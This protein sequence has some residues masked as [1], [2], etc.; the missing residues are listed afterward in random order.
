MMERRTTLVRLTNHDDLDVF[1]DP[2]LVVA[3]TAG[4]AGLATVWWK[5]S[6]T[7]D[8]TVAVVVKGT[9]REVVDALGIP[10]R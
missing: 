4:R 6:V 8:Q 2:A 10:W 5:D 9:P 1:I 3:V 7:N